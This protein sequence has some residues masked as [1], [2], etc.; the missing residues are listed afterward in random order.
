MDKITRQK[1]SEFIIAKFFEYVV[2]IVST[3]ETVC[4]VKKPKTN[5][6]LL[7]VL[8]GLLLRQNI[9]RC[10]HW[11]IRSTNEDQNMSRSKCE[12]IVYA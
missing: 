12:H 7:A 3:V 4:V 1:R 6:H 5:D 11:L 2:G 10:D 8:K 9:T